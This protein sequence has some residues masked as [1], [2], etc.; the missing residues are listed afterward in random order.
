[1][2]DILEMSSKSIIIIYVIY[3]MKPPEIFT[4]ISMLPKSYGYCYL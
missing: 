3:F 4:Q 2:P 1:M